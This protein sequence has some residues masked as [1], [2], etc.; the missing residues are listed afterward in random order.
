VGKGTIEGVQSLRLHTP[1]VIFD[2]PW[3]T[4]IVIYSI[5]RF[6]SFR[7]PLISVRWRIL[8][9][10]IAYHH[11]GSNTLLGWSF[12]LRKFSGEDENVH[13]HLRQVIEITGDR[14]I[15]TGNALTQQQ[16][17]LTIGVY[18]LQTVHCSKRLLRSCTHRYFLAR[19]RTDFLEHSLASI[20][21]LLRQLYAYSRLFDP[22]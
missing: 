14:I 11:T 21:R 12:P 10:A 22:R 4:P 6:V 8:L 16:V 5:G 18:R 3:S 15:N 13:R 20:S 19:G 17:G 2:Y 7:I 9:I 1:E